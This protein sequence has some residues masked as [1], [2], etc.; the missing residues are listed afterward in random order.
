M[1]DDMEKFARARGFPSYAAM[2]GFYR[3]R[4][5]ALRQ[6]QGYTTQQAPPKNWLQGLLDQ[7]PWHPSFLFGH[8]N[9]KL[10]EKP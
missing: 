6:P 9:K 2:Q 8:V 3:S 10:N 4:S 1:A 7:I 5:Q